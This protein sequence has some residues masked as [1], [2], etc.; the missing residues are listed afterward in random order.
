MI[1]TCYYSLFKGSNVPLKDM[2][3]DN[4]HFELGLE[5][6]QHLMLLPGDRCYSI[7]AALL[8]FGLTVYLPEH[9]LA[10]A[11]SYI[12]DLIV[13]NLILFLVFF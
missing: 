8:L 9:F 7:G 2:K 3:S 13:L 12:N 4:Q 10:E 5:V 11:V 6:N 1:I